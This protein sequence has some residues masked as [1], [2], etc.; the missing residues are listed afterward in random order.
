MYIIGHT[1]LAYLFIKPI[2]KLKRESIPPVM[3]L[4]IFIFAN[5]IDSIHVGFFRTIGHNFIGI[6]LFS[7]FW[8]L[9]FNKYK[10]IKNH[11]FPI[12]LLATTTHIFTDYLFSNF[13]F[14]F[15]FI[16]RGFSVFGFN[17]VEDLYIECIL[18]GLWVSVFIGSDDFRRFKVFMTLE[19]EKFIKS[20]KINKIFNPDLFI[21]YLF[22]AFYLFVIVQFIVFLY[23]NYHY[24]LNLIW[25]V[26]FFQIANIL[27]IIIFSLVLFGKRNEMEIE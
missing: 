24:I 19:R 1:A 26:W 2:Y 8:L 27:F 11:H 4:F 25:Y 9:F 6:F 12:L 20:F 10:I 17:S 3:V 18:I 14:F 23:I 13:L 22:I 15:P 21:F 16:D 5:I 7:G